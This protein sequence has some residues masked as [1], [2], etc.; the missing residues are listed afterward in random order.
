M[1]LSKDS[2]K[3]KYLLDKD[4]IH[5]IIDMAMSSCNESP[6]RKLNVYL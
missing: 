6:V 3:R 5:S 2:T 1:K 4:A